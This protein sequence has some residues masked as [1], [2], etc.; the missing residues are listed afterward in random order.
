MFN[1]QADNDE[2]DGLNNRFSRRI[3]YMPPANVNDLILIYSCRDIFIFPLVKE[4]ILLV[5]DYRFIKYIQ[6]LF[7]CQNENI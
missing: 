3:P 5:F 2:S 6:L 7:G 4:S 1:Q